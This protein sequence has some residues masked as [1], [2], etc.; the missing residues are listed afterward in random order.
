MNQFVAEA[1]ERQTGLHCAAV[2]AF[3]LHHWVHNDNILISDFVEFCH[4]QVNG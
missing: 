2:R 3:Y 4:R 1:I